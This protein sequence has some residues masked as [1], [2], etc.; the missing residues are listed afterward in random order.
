MSLTTLKN[1]VTNYMS[2]ATKRS[3]K[4]TN[5]QWMY[6][7]PYGQPETTSSVILRDGLTPHVN[8]GFSVT[9]ATRNIGAVGQNMLMSKS[10]TPYKGVYPRGWG[11][12][13]GRYPDGPNNVSLNIMPTYTTVS[14]QGHI[15]KPPVL[16]NRG[17][18]ERRYK[19]I[20]NG[21]YPNN[22]VQPNYTGNLTDT[23]SQ[24]MYL[25][26]KSAA[27]DCH[28]DV[29]RT[30]KYENYYVRGGSTGCKST[31]ANGYTMQMMQ[32]GAAYTKN[33]YQP[34]DC[35]AHTLHLQRKCQNPVGLQKPFPYK[36]PTGTG[37][38]RGGTSVTNVANACNT[39]S[40]IQLTPPAW[41]TK[42]ALLNKDGTIP[43]IRQQLEAQH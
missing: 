10:A 26:Q 17:M 11:G 40:N 9:G 42:E 25:Q 5:Q 31:P 39:S 13:R 28:L 36:V 14:I 30:Y 16:S 23:A 43:T 33:I 20:R 7:G 18:L 22:W 32:S 34:R 21:Q 19:W 1:K 41:Y 4:R 8:A 2:S 12:L 3:G 37:V 15:V 29:N 35:S 6:Q 27:N 38:L 24:G